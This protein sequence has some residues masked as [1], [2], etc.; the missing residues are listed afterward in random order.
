M[1]NSNR[2]LSSTP[3]Q[4]ITS[5]ISFQPVNAGLCVAACSRSL[6]GLVGSNMY[7]SNMKQLMISVDT[8]QFRVKQFHLSV[9][10]LVPYVAQMNPSVKTNEFQIEQ[11]GITVQI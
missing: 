9:D 1:S 5:D 4:H 11:N 3:S 8:N 7:S 6:P 10:V 2:A